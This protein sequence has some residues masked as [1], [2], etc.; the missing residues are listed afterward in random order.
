MPCC[1]GQWRLVGGMEV[2]LCDEHAPTL[3]LLKP[4]RDDYEPTDEETDPLRPGG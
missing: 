2:E 1:K 4:A 3:P